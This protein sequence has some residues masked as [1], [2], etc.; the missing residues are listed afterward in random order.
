MCLRPSQSSG[1]IKSQ[2]GI[3]HLSDILL[4]LFQKKSFGCF[5]CSLRLE[6]R[7]GLFSPQT[8][9]RSAVHSQCHS[10]S[11]TR[12]QGKHGFVAHAQGARSHPC[13]EESPRAL[14]QRVPAGD[15]GVLLL[16][17]LVMPQVE[18]Q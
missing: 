8:A 4:C 18:P 7:G 13:Y 10:V 14:G 6:V 16:S 2:S 9:G 1:F 5:L 12:R 15:R 11:L 17:L 3:V